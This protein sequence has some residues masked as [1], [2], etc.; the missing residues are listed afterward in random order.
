MRNLT[1]ILASAGSA[2]RDVVEVT[3]FL[4]KIA[5]AD[6]LTSAYVAY[7]EGEAM[8]ARTSVVACIHF[9]RAQVISWPSTLKD[10][11]ERC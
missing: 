3:I 1:A 9:L 5:D 10:L 6:A 8:P 7:W 4:T 11:P 2:L